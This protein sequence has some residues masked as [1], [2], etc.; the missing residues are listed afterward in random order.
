MCTSYFTILN[1]FLFLFACSSVMI[2]SSHSCFHLSGFF[3]SPSYHLHS[4][5]TK[6]GSFASP[7]Q[8]S[9]VSTLFAQWL[10]RHPAHG[11]AQSLRF[12]VFVILATLALPIQH[13][14]IRIS[15]S[16]TFSAAADHCFLESEFFLSLCQFAVLQCFPCLFGSFFYSLKIIHFAFPFFLIIR[17]C[18]DIASSLFPVSIFFRLIY[19]CSTRIASSAP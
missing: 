3:I 5:H 2:Y 1:F 12:I 8:L 11:K 13:S 19:S 9:I 15:A 14:V 6:Q 4:S 18:S 16:S 7:V 17:F 10:Q